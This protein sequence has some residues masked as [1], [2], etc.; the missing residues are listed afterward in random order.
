MAR[1]RSLRSGRFTT[2]RVWE[3]AERDLARLQT[4]LLASGMQKAGKD[5]LASALLWTAQRMPVPVIKAMIEHYLA[6]EANDFLVSR[7]G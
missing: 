5:D 2:A 7:A 1:P 3:F 6:E 4:D